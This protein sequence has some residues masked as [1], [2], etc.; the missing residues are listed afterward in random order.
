M[1]DIDLNSAHRQLG[2]TNPLIQCI[3]NTVVQQFSANVLLAVGASPAMLDHEADAAQFTQIASGLLVNFGTAT[4]H[5]FLA[6]DSAIDAA[7]THEK[8]WVLDPVSIGA[9]DYRT[10]RIRRAAAAGP[11]AIRGNASEIAALA[12]FGLGGR[13]VDSTDDVDAVLPAAA[14]LARETGAVVAVSGPVD[15]IVAHIDGVDHVAHVHGGHALMP[16]VIGT[17]C[18]LGAVTAAYLAAATDTTVAEA[19]TSSDARAAEGTSTSATL[20]AVIAAHA[21]FAAAGASAGEHATGPGSYAV[22]FL[23]ALHALSAEELARVRVEVD[24]LESVAS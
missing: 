22:A 15:A 12:G 3:T 2:A 16:L 18:S 23:D 20:T 24:A 1:V 14:E 21:H 17:G 13:G 9:A 8:P 6:A 7:T 10:T 19:A 11:T 5:Q 4:S